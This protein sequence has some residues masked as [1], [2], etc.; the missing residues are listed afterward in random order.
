[1]ALVAP[2]QAT[3]APSHVP[4]PFGLFT[5]VTP[6]PLGSVRWENGLTWRDQLCGDLPDVIVPDCD[7]P[8]GIPVSFTAGQAGGDALPFT[9]VG[10]F[11]C[12]PV[13]W[14]PEEAQAE[15]TA[16]L[17]AREE[18]KTARTVVSFLTTTAGGDLQGTTVT[19]TGGA[20]G[21]LAA[22]E[23][24]LAATYGSQ[25]IVLASLAALYEL[26]AAR[27]VYARGSQMVTCAGTP[28]AVVR[29]VIEGFSLG[30]VPQPL[31]ARGEPFAAAH[32]PA[33]NFD[34]AHNDMYATAMRSYA[35]G[36]TTDCGA[37]YIG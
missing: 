12:S 28:L 25:G 17:L 4:A 34:H 18:E 8:S 5:A 32:I 36:W 35:A 11:L 21:D 10:D 2:A 26:S 33:N 3:D 14:T 13:A 20:A 6:A 31:L 24:Q 19:T 22:L 30:I 9:V 16:R 23:A 37:A 1:V 29:T 7:A 27:A 15:A